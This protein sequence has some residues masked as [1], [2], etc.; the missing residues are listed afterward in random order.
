MP[1]KKEA[2]KRLLEQKETTGKTWRE[3]S[4]E[5]GIPAGTLARIANSAGRFWPR[6]WAMV[7]W[8]DFGVQD[9]RKSKT[10]SRPRRIADMSTRALRDAFENRVVMA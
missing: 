5:Y 9:V 4:E 7:L 3:M 8:A 10:A 6:K 1:T 2:A